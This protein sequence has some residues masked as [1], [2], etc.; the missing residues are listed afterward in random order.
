[1]NPSQFVSLLVVISLAIGMRL[2]KKVTLHKW[3]M[4]STVAADVSLVLYLTFARN[5]VLKAVDRA[6]GES[7]FS[8]ILMIHIGFAVISIFCY[9]VGIRLGFHIASGQ[10]QYLKAH[11]INARAM[12]F[13]RVLTFLTAFAIPVSN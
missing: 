7:E 5:A 11:R 10:R 13:F 12:L 4:I 2:H 6:V 1:M 3:W 9:A 8:P